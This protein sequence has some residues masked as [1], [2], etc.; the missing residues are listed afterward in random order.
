MRKSKTARNRRNNKMK[1]LSRR[2]TGGS[3]RNN[4]RRNKAKSTINKNKRRI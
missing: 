4:Y 1:Q 3:V 2:K